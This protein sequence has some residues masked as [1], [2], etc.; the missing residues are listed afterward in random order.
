VEHNL[1]S[2][3]EQALDDEPA[4]PEDT[5]REA[6]VHGRRIRRR[7]GLA[8]GG[9]VAAV[10]AV[11]VL[12]LNVLLNPGQPDPQVVSPAGMVWAP[13]EPHCTWPAEKDVSEVSLF[14][15]SEATGAQKA[16]LD[17]ALKA[18]TRIRDLHFESRATAYERFVQLWKDS[19][20][21]VQSVSPDSLPESY[22]F[23]LA[24]PRDYDAVAKRYG[25]Q[26]G[27]D[28]MVGRSCPGGATE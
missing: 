3:F 6:M 12:G 25:K 15:T 5:V 28:T 2:L 27:V 23:R 24:D 10:V 1:R 11:V 4:P 26:P 22:R 7:R 9:G 20:D 17:Q 8:A 21:F 16:V 19:P 13:A 14:L 18:D